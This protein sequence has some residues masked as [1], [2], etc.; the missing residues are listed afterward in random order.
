[1]SCSFKL[2]YL[3]TYAL[4]IFLLGLVCGAFQ[5]VSKASVVL[6]SLFVVDILPLSSFVHFTDHFLYNPWLSCSPLDFPS[7]I[8]HSINTHFLTLFHCTFIFLLSHSIAPS[9]SS[10]VFCIF[11]GWAYNFPNSFLVFALGIAIFFN[12]VQIFS[13]S[14]LWSV[15]CLHI[16]RCVT[17]V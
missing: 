10:I 5:F 15:Q 17:S 8:T 11:S 3:I 14:Q 16:L 13:P 1:M 6:P 2:H 7:Q 12:L 4:K 9:V